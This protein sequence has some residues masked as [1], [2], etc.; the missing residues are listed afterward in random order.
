M[1]KINEI[2]GIG[3]TVT[4]T[5]HKA[6]Q[7]ND[8]EQER[9]EEIGHSFFCS[10]PK[11]LKH[12]SSL[13]NNIGSSKKACT[14]FT[15]NLSQLVFIQEGDFVKMTLDGTAMTWRISEINANEAGTNCT[16]TLVM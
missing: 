1:G 3:Q 15:T 5:W 16:L 9:P 2:R 14:V 13:A 7:S 10:R 11:G 4:A 8:G 12:S 6:I